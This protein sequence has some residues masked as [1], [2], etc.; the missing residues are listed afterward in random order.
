MSAHDGDIIPAADRSLAR[1]TAGLTRRGLALAGE[2]EKRDP[3]STV[4]RWP[5]V[6]SVDCGGGVMMDFVLVTPG[7]ITLAWRADFDS[8]MVKDFDEESES[9][10]V[11]K[12]SHQDWTVQ[13]PRVVQVSRPFYIGSCAVTQAQ[14]T[15]LKGK[16]KKKWEKGQIIDGPPDDQQSATGI[17]FDECRELCHLLLKTSGRDIRLPSEAEWLLARSKSPTEGTIDRTGGNAKDVGEW[18]QDAFNNDLSLIPADGSPSMDGGGVVRV[19]R[20]GDVDMSAKSCR[21]SSRR[22]GWAYNDFP[23]QSART[24]GGMSDNY[25]QPNVGFRVVVDVPLGRDLKPAINFDCGEDVMIR[26]RLVPPGSFTRKPQRHSAQEWFIGGRWHRRK[27]RVI[28]EEVEICI[29]RPFYIGVYT[30]TRAQ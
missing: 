30:T 16:R 22:Y 3:A 1:V 17:S 25:Y 6:L 27:G 10:R 20:G 11:P 19:V 23:D 2:L 15:A 29:L 4:Q 7:M 24:S 13:P 26:F 5:K 9:Q 12:R 8:F 21:S 18:C 14:W 28:R